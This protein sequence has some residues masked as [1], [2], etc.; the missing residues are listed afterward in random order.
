MLGILTPRE[1]R[2]VVAFEAHKE[3]GGEEGRAWVIAKRPGVRWT[4]SAF[5]CPTACVKIQ[6]I[7]ADQNAPRSI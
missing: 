6:R 5:E 2:D 4:S 7:G 1:I 3:Q